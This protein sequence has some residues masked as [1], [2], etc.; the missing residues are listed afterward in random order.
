MKK[1][2]LAQVLSYKPC[3]SEEKIV[4]L[5]DGRSELSVREIVKLDIP[6]KDKVWVLCRPHFLDTKEKAVKFVVFCAEQCLGIFEAAYPEDRRPRQAIELVKAYLRNPEA[7]SWEKLIEVTEAAAWAVEGATTAAAAAAA[8]A[9]ARAAEAAAAARSAQ[10]VWGV[11]A[12]RAAEKAEAATYKEQL[13]YL[14]EIIGGA[15]AA[16]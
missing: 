3:Y 8:T 7:V 4:E 14:V 16:Q 1:I 12:A 6:A 2:T 10:L 9:V 13:N 5:F 11:W 15:S